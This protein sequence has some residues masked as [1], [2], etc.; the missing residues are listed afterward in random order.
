MYD[1]Y[2]VLGVSRDASLDEIKQVYRELARKYHPDNYDE[3]PL[4]DLAAEKMQEINQAYD[5][6]VA[7]RKNGGNV[8]GDFDLSQVEQFI[9]SGRYEEAQLMLDN[10]AINQR[11]AH[12]YYLSGSVLYQRG[13]Y[14]EAYSNFA[15]ACRMDP[16]NAQYQASLQQMNRRHNGGGYRQQ[17]YAGGSNCSAC[18]LCQAMICADCCCEC[19][20]G[21]LI[22]CC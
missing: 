3:N 4:K 5:Q 13:W 17:Q 2:A 11:S 22:S 16:T 15:T 21:D 14:D 1:P 19:M 12:W 18:D 8:G 9:Q 7:E 10:V 20:G 6:I